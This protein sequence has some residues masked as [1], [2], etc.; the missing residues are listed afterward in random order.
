MS[1]IKYLFFAVFELI[2]S[3]IVFNILCDTHWGR[4]FNY[5]HTLCV[6]D[7][8]KW[9]FNYNFK[10]FK[11]M[12]FFV[13]YFTTICSIPYSLPSLWIFLCYLTIILLVCVCFCCCWR[14]GY[15]FDTALLLSV[16]LGMFG[17]DRFYLGYPAIGLMKF[18]TLGFM[19]V[20]QLVDI[21]LIAT[22]TVGPADGSAYVIPY[23]GPGISVIRSDNWTYRR[24]QSDW[25]TNV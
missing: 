1:A 23:Y 19:F 16:F 10:Q 22:Q 2:V 6:D 12:F 11:N 14:N 4:Y 15:H 3:N 18:C 17:V 5:K 13:Y 7:F 24:P 25:W 20:G 9:I 21:V 8:L